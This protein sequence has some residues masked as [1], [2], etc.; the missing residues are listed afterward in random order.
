[1]MRVEH[2]PAANTLVV[3][4]KLDAAAWG[5]FF[6]WIGVALMAGIGWGLGLLGVGAITLVGQVTRKY[7]GLAVEP[8]W[9]VVAFF[10]LLGGVGELLGLQFSLVPIMLIVAGM[11][12]LFSALRK[13]SA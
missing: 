7:F 12:L 2:L 10:F 11:A 13:Q 1:M 4:H 9:V 6:V 3:A 5:L 8:F